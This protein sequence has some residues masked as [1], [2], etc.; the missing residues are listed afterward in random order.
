MAQTFLK[1]KIHIP[2]A[3]FIPTLHTISLYDLLSKRYPDVL[4]Q[5][6]RLKNEFA[7]LCQ[8]TDRYI[9]GGCA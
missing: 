5:P 6:G 3:R 1:D 8:L 7:A 9:Y 4:V 2:F